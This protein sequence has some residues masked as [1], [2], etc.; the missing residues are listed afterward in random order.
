MA[1]YILPRLMYPAPAGETEEWLIDST[2]LTYINLGPII[3]LINCQDTK[4][5]MKDLKMYVTIIERKECC[6]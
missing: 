2:P 4:I 5:Q 6:F 3:V 1:E